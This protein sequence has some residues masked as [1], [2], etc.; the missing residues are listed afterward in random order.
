M[1]WSGF[2]PV[3]ANATAS[4]PPNFPHCLERLMVGLLLKIATGGF[5]S[6]KMIFNDALKAL[7]ENYK[8]RCNM[9]QKRRI[10]VCNHYAYQAV[11]PQT[12]NQSSSLYN[13][14]EPL[15]DDRGNFY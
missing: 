1:F 2:V 7:F 12:E 11:Y 13:R 14:F 15:S 5:Y 4:P 8:E 9:T 10:R 6:L 3:G